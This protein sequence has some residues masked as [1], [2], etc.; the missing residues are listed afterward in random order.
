MAV[1]DFLNELSNIENKLINILPKLIDRLKGFSDTELAVI[2]RE[3]D[4]FEQL[5]S[6][7]YNDSV[8]KLMQDYDGVAENVFR[9]ANIRGLDTKVAS[10][11][12]LQLIKDLDAQAIFRIGQEISTKVKSELL[13]GIIDGDTRDNIVNRLSTTVVGELTSPQLN[14]IVG[15]SFARFSNTATKKAFEEN[16]DQRFKYVGA[17]KENPRIRPLCKHVMSNSQNEKGFTVAE[18]LSYPEIGGLKLSFSGR[19]GYNC[20]HDWVAVLD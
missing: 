5:N 18:I 16:P 7:G 6:L 19:G 1:N 17:S 11:S 8:E 3:I 14:T 10:A 4:F 2:A 13:R 15:D 12:Q 20:R 9:E